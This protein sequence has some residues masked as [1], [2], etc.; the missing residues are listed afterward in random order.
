ME[1]M[2]Y[3]DIL[4]KGM[5]A[6][7]SAHGHHFS[8]P[9]LKWATGMMKDR[10]G[11]KGEAPDRKKFDDTMR[12]YGVSLERNEGYYDG[13]YVWAMA[14]SDYFGSSITDEQHLAMYV[15]DYIDDVDGNPTRPFDEFIINCNSKGVDIPWKDMI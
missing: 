2:D 12:A 1:R 11:R 15:K 3:Y 4:P 9:M 13:P 14:K 10:Q 6:Y 5:D 8:E 7:L